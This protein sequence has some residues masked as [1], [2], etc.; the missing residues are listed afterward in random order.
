MSG[1][2][3]K[4]NARMFAYFSALPKFVQ[5]SISQSDVQFAT[6]DEL[7]QFAEKLLRK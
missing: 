4:T 6:E 2:N 7:K 5:E 3:L 1:N